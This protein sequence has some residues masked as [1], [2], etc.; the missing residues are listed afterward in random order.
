MND[1]ELTHTHTQTQFFLFLSLYIRCLLKNI[2]SGRM[3]P[4]LCLTHMINGRF[5]GLE[6]YANDSEVKNTEFIHFF[7]NVCTDT[8]CY[9]LVLERKIL[10][11]IKIT[12]TL[13]FST[14]ILV[15][16]TGYE[17]MCST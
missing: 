4:K 8:F 7:I 5:N 11:S 16:N 17:V 6:I 1:L 14:S 9:F 3:N 15:Y 12:I 10:P 2:Q 13:T